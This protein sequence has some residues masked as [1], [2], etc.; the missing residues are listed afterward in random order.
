MD[1]EGNDLLRHYGNGLRQRN[2][3]LLV[4]RILGGSSGNRV[5]GIDSSLELYKV[6]PFMFQIKSFSV[7]DVFY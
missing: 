5:L 4:R 7:E 6:F 1:S 3:P 2:V